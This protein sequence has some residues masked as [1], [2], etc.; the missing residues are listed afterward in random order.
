MSQPW[1]EAENPVSTSTSSADPSTS[2][3]QSLDSGP[4][5]AKK[6]KVASKWQEDW[7]HYN[8]KRSMKVASYVHC[9]V[10]LA[11]FSVASG[12]VHGLKRHINS[13]KHSDFARAQQSTNDLVDP[14]KATK[15]LQNKSYFPA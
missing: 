13:K 3:T 5:P 9:N 14:A 12:G 11:D 7:K 2:D 4:T 6:T 8:M 10:C 15:I 1:P